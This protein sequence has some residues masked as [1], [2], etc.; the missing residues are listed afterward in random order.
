M[1]DDTIAISKIKDISLAQIKHAL[2]NLENEKVESFFKKGVK[3]N[4]EMYAEKCFVEGNFWQTFLNIWKLELA[5]NFD[6]VNSKIQE[7]ETKKALF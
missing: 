7:F 6:S 3:Y 4:P 1:F 5:Q 2:Q